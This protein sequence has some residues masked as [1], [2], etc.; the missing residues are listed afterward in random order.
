MPEIVISFILFLLALIALFVVGPIVIRLRQWQ[1][2]TPKFEA[3]DS[4]D[5]VT[6]E[7]GKMIYDLQ[8]SGFLLRGQWRV[9]G[10]FSATGVLFL[11]ERPR[12][13]DIV[14]VVIVRAST[15]I[16]TT[17]ILETLFENGGRIVTSNSQYLLGAPQFPD[18]TPVWLPGMPDAT[19]L[20]RIHEKVTD[21]IGGSQ[22][23]ISIGEDCVGF[24]LDQ[25]K[26]SQSH[27][28]N[29]GYFWRDESQGILRPTL[30]GAI[31]M[32]LRNTGPIKW[33]YF[34]KRRRQ[35]REL[36]RELGIHYESDAE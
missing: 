6:P 22:K 17:L 15:R 23:R 4:D 3:C 30:K 16:V 2:L 20:Y 19:S 27:L 14:R 9:S 12:S 24:L 36:L 34:A 5:V 8:N 18:V 1:S 11:A 33:L 10:F 35:T 13:H 29:T 31:F 28:V 26:S 25:V 32:S 7:A 21:F